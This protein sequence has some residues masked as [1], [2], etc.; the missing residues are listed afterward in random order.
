MR[1]NVT[2]RYALAALILS[3]TPAA[4][5]QQPAPVTYPA[6]ELGTLAPD[7]SLAGATRY[8]TLKDPVH[9]SDFRGKTVVLA[10][11]Y[12]ARTKG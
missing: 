12:R 1:F 4:R 11:F 2:A 8:G 9:L 5:A 7:F 10:F 6:P 3:G